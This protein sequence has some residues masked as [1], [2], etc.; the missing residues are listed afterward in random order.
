[1]NCT[2]ESI[3]QVLPETMSLYHA[4]SQIADSRKKRGLRYPLTVVLTV[5]TVAKLC[6][7]TELRGIAQWAQYRARQLWRALGDE[8]RDTMP[9]WTTYS[10]VLKQVDEQQLESVIQRSLVGKQGD[11]GQRI[12][13]G[14][15][16][17][18]TIPPG[19]SRGEHLLAVYAPDQRLVLAQ[20][21]VGEKAN[22]IT[23]APQVLAQANLRGTIVTGDAM[24]TQ[25]DLSKQI[26]AA[27]ADYIWIV[28]ENQPR[29]YQMIERL[30]HSPSPHPGHGAMA[31]DFQTA[32]QSNKGHGRVE[33]RTLT[34]SHLLHDYVDW[35]GIQQVFR[36]QRLR[37]P[38][39]APASTEVVYGITSLL[40]AQADPNRLLSLTRRHWAI[41]NQ[42]HYVRDVSLR[43]D[44]CR[45]ASPQAQRCMALLNNLVLA[46]L[47]ATPFAFLPDAQRFFNAHL[48]H[49]LA[50]LL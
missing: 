11:G 13:D 2:P 38:K 31:T 45:L 3:E 48:N 15:T 20:T 47:P 6:G 14:K 33:R 19:Q 1:M 43:E 23:V 32:C 22:E 40:P 30:F 24:F 16:L 5:M 46:L 9:H 50:L 28:K 37:Q 7:E 44:A 35:P 25:R 39:C 8:G 12:L 34:T 29:L 10:R 17:R 4:F 41:E 42:L 36:L 26:L 21:A 49:A 27:E 18:G